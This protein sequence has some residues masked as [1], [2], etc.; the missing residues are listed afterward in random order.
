[1]VRGN[2]L[3]LEI[4]GKLL[5]CADGLYTR[6]AFGGRNTLKYRLVDH[7]RFGSRNDPLSCVLIVWEFP[8]DI[9][10]P[11]RH[12]PAHKIINK[13]ASVN[14][15]LTSKTFSHSFLERFQCDTVTTDLLQFRPSNP[16]TNL[17]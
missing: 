11:D 17:H 16:G 15:N 4:D 1:M 3:R 5:L 13:A 7:P 9:E 14:D 6:S 8:R 10:F 2:D 12:P